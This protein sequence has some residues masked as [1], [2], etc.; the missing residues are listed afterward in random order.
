MDTK[1]TPGKF[2]TCGDN[3]EHVYVLNG[4]GYNRIFAT[5]QAGFIADTRAEEKACIRTTAEE[6]RATAALFAAASRLYAEGERY[7]PI[8]QDL[9]RDYPGIWTDIAS[10]YGIATPNGLSAALAAARGET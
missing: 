10:K 1:F 8:L 2:E 5:V 7:L 4:R 6:I 9:E 3:G